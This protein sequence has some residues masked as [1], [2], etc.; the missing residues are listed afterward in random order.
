MSKS[1]IAAEKQ[2]RARNL[3][4]NLSRL[5]KGYEISSRGG[6]WELWCRTCERG[7]RVDKFKE[8]NTRNTV[9]LIN[10]ATSCAGRAG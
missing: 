2:L 4:I 5:K 6:R 1:S 9:H 10:H 7:W 8:L 3:K